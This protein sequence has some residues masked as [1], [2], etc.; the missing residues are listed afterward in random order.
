VFKE[1]ALTASDVTLNIPAH[2]IV[3]LLLEGE[4]KKPAEYPAGE[5][6]ING[7][8]ATSGPSFARL[9]YTNTSGRVA[10]MRA[11]NSSGLS[12]ALALPATSGSTAGA[13]GL[14][15]P[16]GTADLS[17]EAGP[18]VIRKIFVYSW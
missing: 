16:K 18:A 3:L 12:T 14:I 4:E 6:E 7:I 17:F 2:D 8:Q 10:V 1:H 15:L 11:K 13:I 9:E 5:S